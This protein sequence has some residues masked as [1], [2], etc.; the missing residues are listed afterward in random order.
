[1]GNEVS[2]L[3]LLLQGLFQ[4]L[5]HSFGHDFEY[6]VVGA[7]GEALADPLDDFAHGPVVLNHGDVADQV[8]VELVVSDQVRSIDFQLELRHY[9]AAAGGT[10]K[11]TLQGNDI[12]LANGAA[13]VADVGLVE[14][15]LVQ[16]TLLDLRLFVLWRR[17]QLRD[18]G[19]AF[20][21]NAHNFCDSPQHV[22]LTNER[23]EGLDCFVD[24]L[25]LVPQETFLLHDF[26]LD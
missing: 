15:R 5:A 10:E 4:V 19:I 11:Q 22:G 21:F 18:V 9:R 26:E 6:K 12:F 13:E 2:Q 16:Q 14:Q 20:R 25:V 1:M 24:Q 3:R 8:F 23:A 17:Q 7:I